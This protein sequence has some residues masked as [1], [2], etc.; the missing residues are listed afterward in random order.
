MRGHYTRKQQ[1]KASRLLRAQGNLQGR[2]R[3]RADLSE[4]PDYPPRGLIIS[5]GEQHPIGQSI[6]ARTPVI[7]VLRSTI[8]LAALSEAQR[9]AGRLAHAMVGYIMW[10]TPQVSG[11]RP[12]LTETFKGTRQ[13]VTKEGEHLRIPEALAHLWLG[14]HCALTY[15]EEIGACSRIEAEG[16][17]AKAWEALLSLGRTQSQ[18]VAGEKPSERFLR[19]LHALLMQGRILL[20][21]RLGPT[22]LPRTGENLVIWHDD[23]ALY[24]DPEST[25]QAVA[26]FCHESGEVFP[27]PLLA[28]KRELRVEKISECKPGRNDWSTKIGHS[29]HRVLKLNRNKIEA[30]L[31]SE[32]PIP[33]EVTSVTSFQE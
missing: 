22:A 11:L 26:R 6:L 25:F 32:L 5:T 12:L 31:G 16:L 33:D 18:L 20:S 23:D 13:R 30:V 1:V 9:N 10:L 15:A 8:D 17:R 28:L 19:V 21:P 7:E 29:T 2:G 24:M 4:R 14:L 27:I 3:L